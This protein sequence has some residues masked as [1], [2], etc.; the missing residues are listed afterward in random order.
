MATTSGTTTF[1]LDILQIC[2]EAF[3]RAGLEMRSGYDLRTARRSLSLMALEWANRGI[4][5]W[6][7]ESGTQ[8]LTAGTASYSLGSDIIDLM[9]H[10][11]RKGSGTSQTDYQ[12]QRV[13]VSTYAQRTVKNIQGRPTDIYIDRGTDGVTVTL[14]PVPDSSDYT[15]GYYYLRRMEDL[16]NNTNNFDAPERMIP[17]LVAGLAFHIAQKRPESANRVMP[18]KQYYEEQLEMAFRE[19]REKA[20]WR[21]IPHRYRL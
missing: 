3:E 21:L 4:N 14:W 2:E 11:I 1:N 8:A 15:L 5:L 19:D 20:D 13:S 10:F 6:T 9:E 16:G 12:L 18:L 17:A 7:V